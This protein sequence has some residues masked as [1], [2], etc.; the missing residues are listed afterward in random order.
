MNWTNLG[1]LYLRIALGVTFLYAV[2]DRSGLWGPPGA[3][4]VNWG[5][6]YYFSLYTAKITAFIP[7][8]GSISQMVRNC[9]GDSFRSLFDRWAVHPA[10]RS[11]QRNAAIHFRAFDDCN[12]RFRFG[13]ILTTN[14]GCHSGSTACNVSWRT[15]YRFPAGRKRCRS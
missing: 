8:S 13:P 3:R 7:T 14:P 4:G 6:F 15:F 2:G 9:P 10:G 5:D 12:D 11:R 1:S